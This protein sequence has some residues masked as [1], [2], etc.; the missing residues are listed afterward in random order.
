MNVWLLKVYLIVIFS[1]S[2]LVLP[3]SSTLPPSLQPEVSPSF[4]IFTPHDL[5]PHLLQSTHPITSTDHESRACPARSR[6][7]PAPGGAPRRF[8]KFIASPFLAGSSSHVSL[9]WGSINVISH[10]FSCVYKCLILG[11]WMRACVCVYACIHVHI[12]MYWLL[13]RVDVWVKVR[14]HICFYVC[15]I[16]AWY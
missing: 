12:H 8:F 1:Y 16:G 10:V 9:V 6:P 14:V 2:A 13:G 4:C 15:F 7:A 3:F 11:S 5:P